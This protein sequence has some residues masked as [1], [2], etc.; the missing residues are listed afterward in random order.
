M[1]LITL[2]FQQST[3]YSSL[4]IFQ[5]HWCMEFTFHN[6]LYIIIGLVSSTLIFCGKKLPGRGLRYSQV[7]IFITT[8]PWSSSRHC[9]PIRNIHSSNGNCPF[10]CFVDFF[11]PLST[12]LPDLTMSNTTGVFSE[13]G[14]A[15][16]SQPL[17]LGRILWRGPSC[18]SFQFYVL[19]FCFVLVLCFVP[20]MSCVSGLSIYVS[21]RSSL[22]FI[23]YPSVPARM[24]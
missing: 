15:Y 14:T 9:R 6:N 3:S 21:L 2:L 4:A 16:S 24:K 12:I 8:T 1:T 7:E 20:N 11:F 23:L 5:Q 10:P 17:H 13:T 19:R 18:S 22:I